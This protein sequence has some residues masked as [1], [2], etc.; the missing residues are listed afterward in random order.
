MKLYTWFVQ[1]FEGNWVPEAY[2]RGGLTA[3]NDVEPTGRVEGQIVAINVD[4][5][6]SAV[7]RE[8]ILSVSEYAGAD[9]EDPATFKTWLMSRGIPES[10]ADGLAN[11]PNVHNAMNA[12]IRGQ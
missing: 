9:A 11:A 7:T 5:A 12:H 8:Q 10:A 2:L 6:K 4:L 3:S 1:D